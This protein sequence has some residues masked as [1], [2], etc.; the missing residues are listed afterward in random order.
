MM[1]LSGR[2]GSESPYFIRAQTLLY[3]PEPKPV[4]FYYLAHL[5]L[6]KELQEVG[7]GA[8]G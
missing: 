4:G 7:R 1:L 3:F 2:R 6:G 5:D 8:R